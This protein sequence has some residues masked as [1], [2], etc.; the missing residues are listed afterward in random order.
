MGHTDRHVVT[1][2]LVGADSRPSCRT[3]RSGEVNEQQMNNKSI[4]RQA[5]GSVDRQIDR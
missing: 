2:G 3:H 5:D 1:L 4:N